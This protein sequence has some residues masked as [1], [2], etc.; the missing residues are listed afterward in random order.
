MLNQN[1]IHT[2]IL[3]VYTVVSVVT[4]THINY[5]KLQNKKHIRNLE[6][7]RNRLAVKNF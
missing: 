6:Q 4:V 7:K 5:I 2:C 3:N 1:N